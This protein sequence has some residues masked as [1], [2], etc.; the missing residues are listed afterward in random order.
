MTRE[1]LVDRLLDRS[2]VGGYTNLGY[3]VRSAHWGDRAAD[4]APDA[5]VGKRALVTGAGSG[6]GEAVALGLARLGAEVHLLGRSADRVQ[7]AIER[8]T[9]QLRDERRDEHREVRLHAEACDVSDLAQVRRFALELNARL[10]EDGAALDALVHNAGVLPA[11]RTTSVDGH[12]LTLAT[13]VL[14]PVLMTDLL[15]PA[16]RRSTD[17]SRVVLVSSGGMYT[18][19]LPVEDPEYTAT[20]YRGAVAY[21]RSKR[22]QVDLTP[23]LAER[24]AADGIA[25][26]SMH[27]GWAD[28]P[29]V[30]SSLPA[31]RAI[32]R[33]LLRTS[34]QGADT[35]V[36]LVATEPA[37]RSGLFWHDRAPRPTTYAG[38][39]PASAEDRNRLLS[40]ILQ[41]LETEPE[42]TRRHQ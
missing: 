10:A 15:V 7:P 25:V 14:G 29:G 35:V 28:T 21:A 20:P 37:P 30:A 16:L 42:N 17:G 32:T 3:L 8:I 41:T 19:A 4:P 34:A 39:H 27:P 38:R 9:Q 12:E 40:W 1:S 11:Q 6:L 22:I 13:H 33:P 23:L 18:Q 2:V 26:H 5:L 24:L 31:F 36:W